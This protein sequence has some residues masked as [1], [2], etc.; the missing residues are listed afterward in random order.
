MRRAQRANC[1]EC[2][3][4]P[5]ARALIRSH[6][7]PGTAGSAARARARPGCARSA[8][9]PGCA[10]WATPRPSTSASLSSRS[11]TRGPTSTRVICTCATGPSRSSA[12]SGKP[13]GFRSSS[14]SP[15]CRRRSKSRRP[16]CTA[17]CCR[18]RPRSC[19]APTPSTALCS[20]AGATRPRPR[21][22]WARPARASR[23]STSRPGRCCAATSA[24]SRWAAAP[25]CGSTGTTTGPG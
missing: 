14:P 3:I 7:W 22:S 8:T 18:W 10:G 17:T 15:R 4:R 25:T 12:A 13:A 11:S 1:R 9:G 2:A 19:F 6:P 20:W 16:C 24:A 23:R 21:C 5:A